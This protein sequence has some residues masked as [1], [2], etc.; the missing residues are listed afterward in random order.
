MQIKE[1]APMSSRDKSRTFWKHDIK[2]ARNYNRTIQKEDDELST[3]FK[4]FNEQKRPFL[5]KNIVSENYHDFAEHLYQSTELSR[6]HLVDVEKIQNTWSP[7]SFV[8][9]R[10]T[11][12]EL[13][14]I[15]FGLIDGRPTVQKN[16]NFTFMPPDSP[17]V[18]QSHDWNIAGPSGLNYNK[19]EKQTL[20]PCIPENFSSDSSDA[21]PR[22][23]AP[24]IK[25]TSKSNRKYKDR[26]KK[27]VVTPAVIENVAQTIE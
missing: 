11:I 6:D 1:V 21:G 12:Q 13:K 19:E 10:P 5:S 4:N 18:I 17:V 7:S 8:P 14:N 2:I 25:T 16:L 22:Q 27:F 24:K 15:Y 26:P 3:Q 9:K 23:L 20:L